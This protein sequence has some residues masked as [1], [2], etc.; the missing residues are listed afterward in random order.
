VA[1]FHQHGALKKEVLE[2]IES[3]ERS[4][5][6]DHVFV[7]ALRVVRL[8]LRPKESERLTSREAE[9]LLRTL[10]DHK[11]VREAPAP[12]STFQPLARGLL[13]DFRNANRKQLFKYPTCPP[14]GIGRGTDGQGRKPTMQRYG[15]L[16]Q[17]VFRLWRGTKR[18]DVAVLGAMSVLRQKHPSK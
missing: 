12:P 5:R 6:H 16:A 14:V 10:L 1:S 4:Q 2:K 8:L 13:R 9:I 7:G 17:S 11:C 15:I 3:L 18:F